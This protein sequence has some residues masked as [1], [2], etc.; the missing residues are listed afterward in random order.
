MLYI[1]ALPYKTDAEQLKKLLNPYELIGPIAVHADWEN[2]TFEPYA[3][4]QVAKAEQAV[5]DL[6]GYKIGSMHLRVHIKPG[7]QNG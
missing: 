4:A 3:V 5:E 1:G 6:D 2:P 7:G